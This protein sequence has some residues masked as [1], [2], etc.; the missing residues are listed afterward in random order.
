MYLISSVLMDY[1]KFEP[2]FD[3]THDAIIVGYIGGGRSEEESSFIDMAYIE[4]LPD[5]SRAVNSGGICSYNKHL[6]FE[7][8]DYI[9]TCITQLLYGVYGHLLPENFNQYVKPETGS[10]S[11]KFYCDRNGKH[12]KVSFA[13][14]YGDHT[15]EIGF[16]MKPI[17]PS[18]IRRCTLD[19]VDISIAKK[20]IEVVAQMHCKILCQSVCSYINLKSEFCRF[21]VKYPV[22][23]HPEHWNS[24]CG[25]SIFE[26]ILFHGDMFIKSHDIESLRQRIMEL[27]DIL[28][29]VM[30]VKPFGRHVDK[31]NTFITK[32]L[33]KSA[34]S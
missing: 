26:R 12:Q 14:K 31:V 11:S 32:Q 2:S 13:C 22:S 27:F 33:A 15:T 19:S 23:W 24:D 28:I 5:G 30:N 21:L 16:V 25:L 4:A 3:D 17:G 1:T 8:G 18:V 6:G 7:N 34:G 10:L 9:L 29:T 20:I